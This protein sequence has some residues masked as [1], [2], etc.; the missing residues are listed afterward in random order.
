MAAKG[1]WRGWPGDEWGGW[2]EAGIATD[3]WLWFGDTQQSGL[4]YRSTQ[5]NPSLCLALEDANA[6]LIVGT[7]ANLYTNNRDLGFPVNTNPQIV[8]TASTSWAVATDHWVRI[9]FDPTG[10]AG[11]PCGIIDTGTGPLILN[12]ETIATTHFR[13]GNSDQFSQGNSND[14]VQQFDG[15]D[16]VITFR[17]LGAVAVAGGDYRITGQAGGTSGNNNGGD[18]DF[19]V[20]LKGNSGADGFIN[21]QGGVRFWDRGKS[22]G[23]YAQHDAA[24][25]TALTY[26]ISTH[27]NLT[28]GLELSTGAGA[29]VLDSAAA[30]NL[31]STTGILA[32]GTITASNAAGPAF[33]DAAATTTVPTLCP[34]KAETDTGIGWASDTLHFILGGTSYAN[35]STTLLTLAG[36]IQLTGGG[37]IQNDTGNITLDSAAGIVLD[38]TSESSISWAGVVG[39]KVDDAAVTD[40]KAL[41]GVTPSS[42][43]FQSQSG[44][45]SNV[46]GSSIYWTAGT[47]HGSGTGGSINLLPGN[48]TSGTRGLVKFWHPAG[49]GTNYVSVEHD[50]ANGAVKAAAGVLI[51]GADTTKMIWTGNALR[52]SV[53]NAMVLGTADYE[54]LAGYFG[55]DTV[56]GPV[57]AS[58][59][60]LGLA[61]EARFRYNKDATGYPASTLILGVSATGSA[62]ADRLA[63]G[64]TAPSGF[65]AAANVAGNA[66]FVA[67]QSAG[68]V[69]AGAGLAGATF[70]GTTGAGSAAFAASGLAGGAGGGWTWTT[71][72]GGNGDGAGNGGAGGSFLVNLGA[73]GTGGTPGV[74]EFSIVGAAEVFSVQRTGAVAIVPASGVAL[75]V[76]PV[77]ASVGLLMTASAY[78]NTAGVIDINCTVGGSGVVGHDVSMTTPAAGL[79]NLES[80]YAY[81]CVLVGDA[82]DNAGAN[83]YG[84]NFGWTANGGAAIS[85]ALNVPATF[86]YGLYTLADIY[87]GAADIIT[88]TTTGMKIA[89][90]AAQ[91][92]G[93]FGQTPRIQCAK[94]AFNNWAAFGDVVNALVSLGLFDTA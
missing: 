80:M 72:A 22:T 7:I 94:A 81:N 66:L 64:A 62:A 10:Y 26:T 58:G 16:E 74:A 34:N 83:V 27:A 65:I 14:Y 45:D 9:Y 24:L 31:E 1:S 39:L 79:G 56:T 28:S 84:I 60:F 30:I 70:T 3:E 91:K 15:T 88:D 68:A 48:T 90:A 4:S 38:M 82:Q 61:Q 89:T 78:T 8:V 36:D 52:G 20:G 5:T 87:L 86:T 54:M 63:I 71:G 21:E 76:T 69:T 57:S 40:Y 55:Q 49:A 6:T 13:M 11:G 32:T 51:L 77:A 93:F 47:A 33:I 23:I 17:T 37:T 46:A 59:L 25:T 35:L 85:T 67:T 18:I 42:I 73:S 2:D 41:T 12:D 50:G 75:T 53:N 29:I 44:L 19:I 92:V 43:Y